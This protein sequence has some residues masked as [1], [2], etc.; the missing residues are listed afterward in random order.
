MSDSQ[1]RVEHWPM[2]PETQK[3]TEKEKKQS[4]PHVFVTGSGDRIVDFGWIL[5]PKTKKSNR[6]K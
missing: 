1:T 3:K 4:I 5:P 6:I 2:K